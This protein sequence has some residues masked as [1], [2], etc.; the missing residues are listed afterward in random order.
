MYWDKAVNSPLICL[1]A[2]RLRKNDERGQ[3][4]EAWFFHPFFHICPSQIMVLRYLYFWNL[5]G[6]YEYMRSRDCYIPCLVLPT[7][8]KIDLL[9]YWDSDTNTIFGNIREHFTLHYLWVV[10][11]TVILL[12]STNKHKKYFLG[13]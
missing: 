3:K 12:A 5:C 1:Y 8:K 11:W 7:E 13:L 4:R 6:R 10:N 9:A 2:P